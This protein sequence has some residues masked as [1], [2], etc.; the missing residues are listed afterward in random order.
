MRI[1]TDNCVTCNNKSFFRKQS[2]FNAH[3]SD[4]EEIGDRLFTAELTA[5]LTLICCLD[6]LVRSEM[7]HDHC[8]LILIEDIFFSEFVKLLYGNRRCDVVSEHQIKIDHNKFAA[9]DL[10]DS[11]M[12]SQ[13]LLSH[14]HS[15]NYAL[16][17]LIDL[18]TALTSAFAEDMMISVSI[19]VPHE[20]LPSSFL[21][22]T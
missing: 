5:H 10:I 12:S 15:H 13:Y 3:L 20:R 19:P 18:F 14:C 21:I 17:S 4:V 8:Y 22:P 7:V 6:V 2:V 1:G 16:L 11:G 9:F